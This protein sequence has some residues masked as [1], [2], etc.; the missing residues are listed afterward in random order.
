MCGTCRDEEW[1]REYVNRRQRHFLPPVSPY[2]C[3]REA[4]LD[5]L[6]DDVWRKLIGWMEELVRRHWEGF[7]SGRF[8]FQFWWIFQVIHLRDLEC[9]CVHKTM[10]RML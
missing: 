7:M 5:L 6:F 3:R 1:E 2:R 10:R 4:V 9:I 8:N